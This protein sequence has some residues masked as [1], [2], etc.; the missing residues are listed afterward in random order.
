MWVFAGSCDS[1]GQ[2]RHTTGC[3]TVNLWSKRRMV[4]ARKARTGAAVLKF[5]VVMW[6]NQL[7]ALEMGEVPLEA[8]SL[9]AFQ[10]E[11]TRLLHTQQDSPAC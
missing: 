7:Q 4:K 1:Q 5:G 8:P 10:I 3:G 2:R 9:R 6:F 11:R